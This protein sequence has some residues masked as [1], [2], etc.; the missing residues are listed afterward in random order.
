MHDNATGQ[1]EMQ[2]LREKVAILLLALYL[3]YPGNVLD[4]LHVP[5]ALQTSACP[6]VRC[7]ISLN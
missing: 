7:K 6:P 2:F 1:A 4:V 5:N 3:L